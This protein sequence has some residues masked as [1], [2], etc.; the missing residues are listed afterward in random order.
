MFS[1]HSVHRP[2]PLLPLALASCSRCGSQPSVPGWAWPYRAGISEG[3]TPSLLDPVASP[4][5]MSARPHLTH[6]GSTWS[7]TVYVWPPETLPAMSKAN[8]PSWVPPIPQQESMGKKCPSYPWR[9]DRRSQEIQGT[10]RA[11]GGHWGTGQLSEC[12]G[13]ARGL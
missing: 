6:S 11:L 5:V 4:R 7:F 3:S 9:Q 1:P 2:R 8:H 13:A 12:H 10:C